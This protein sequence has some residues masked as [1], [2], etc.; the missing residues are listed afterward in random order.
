LA[1]LR[2][3]SGEIKD[4][5]VSSRPDV[6]GLILGNGVLSEGFANKPARRGLIGRSF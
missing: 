6:V 1:L 3:H 4:L 5:A 2:S